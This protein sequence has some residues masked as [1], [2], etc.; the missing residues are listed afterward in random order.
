MERARVIIRRIFSLLPSFSSPAKKRADER[1]K[2]GALEPRTIIIR[3][4]IRSLTSSYGTHDLTFRA[5]FVVCAM[6]PQRARQLKSE[7][8]DAGGSKETRVLCFKGKKNR[9][10][11]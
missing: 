10:T 3:L 1:R 11:D 7:H 9:G 8:L 5:F 2:S 4:V 6:S